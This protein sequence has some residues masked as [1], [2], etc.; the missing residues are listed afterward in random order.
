ME[1]FV[2]CVNALESCNADKVT[3]SKQPTTNIPNIVEGDK[4]N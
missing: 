2:K 1:C 4:L 3:K